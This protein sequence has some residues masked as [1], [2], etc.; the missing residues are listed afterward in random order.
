MKEH[1]A[2]VRKHLDAGDGR[3]DTH[4]LKETHERVIGSI[5]HERLIHLM[6]TLSFGAFLLISVA[7]AL[8]RPCLQMFLLIGLFFVLL[9]PYLFHYYFL[10][11]T[12]QRWYALTEEIVAAGKNR[13]SRSA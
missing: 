1:E 6:V 5:Q 7:V 9:V 13:K 4:E 10:E 11:N 3:C 2:Y 8:V 12:V